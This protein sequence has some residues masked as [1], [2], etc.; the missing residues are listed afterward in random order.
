VT[1]DLDIASVTTCIDGESERGGV[2]ASLAV[3]ADMDWCPPTT[4]WPAWT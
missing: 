4:P 2:G 3:V 1:A